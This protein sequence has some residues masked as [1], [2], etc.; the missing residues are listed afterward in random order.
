MAGSTPIQAVA[1]SAPSG[2]RVSRMQAQL[3][4]NVLTFLCV[5]LVVMLTACGSVATS[6]VS[7]TTP[8]DDLAPSRLDVIAR[9]GATEPWATKMP[10]SITLMF[11][12]KSVP[13]RTGDA[14]ECNGD[15]LHPGPFQL[16]S[17]NEYKVDV[18]LVH[19]GGVYKFVYT[20]RGIRTVFQALVLPNPTIISPTPAAVLAR[21]PT[22][23]VTYVAGTSGTTNINGEI[24]QPKAGGEST[25]SYWGHQP[26]TGT[27]TMPV[28]AWLRAGPGWIVL[29]R[30]VVT[31]P[32]GTGFKS[33]KVVDDGAMTGVQVQWR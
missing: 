1:G 25:V 10:V 28:P 11:N 16:V 17:P 7:T 15:Q 29:F 20:H 26:E 18:P 24:S 4:T 30:E 6:A 27:Y 23:T 32:S 14:L 2:L 5:S 19:A 13:L 3:P 9:I 12:A 31:T 22:V 33:V 8:P 21:T